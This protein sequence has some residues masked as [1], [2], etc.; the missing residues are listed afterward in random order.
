MTSPKS[1]LGK[2][3]LGLSG[4]IIALLFIEVG[5]RLFPTEQ[6]NSIVERTSQR[7]QLYRLDP[8]IGWVLKSNARSVHTTRDDLAIP[9]ETNSL[10][11]RDVERTYENQDNTFRILVI[12]DSF[13]EAIDVK[14]EESFPAL[15]EQCL[16]QHLS[17][18]VEVI[19]GG[20]IGYNTGDE[21]L[22]FKNDVH[23]LN[24][25]IGIGVGI[26]RA[27]TSSDIEELKRGYEAESNP[28]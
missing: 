24:G 3:V 22:F 1:M 16:S 17:Q 21:Y 5:L 8:R 4:I 28:G 12:G 7:L 15:V 27:I 11:L 18:P 10:G 26:N 20:V 19:N 13:T 23:T 6:L 14:L 9:I 2:I 25:E